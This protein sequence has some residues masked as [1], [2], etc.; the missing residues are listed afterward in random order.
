MKP[1]TA[2]ML[3]ILPGLGLYVQGYQERAF[4]TLLVST[5]CLFMPILW[6]FLPLCFV[7]PAVQSYKIAN[8][9]FGLKK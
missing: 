6:V 9:T 4:M 5:I 3:N 1:I 7:V 8:G 2:A